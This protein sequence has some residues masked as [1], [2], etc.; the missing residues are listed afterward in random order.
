MQ[1]ISRTDNSSIVANSVPLSPSTW[2][3]WIAVG[4]LSLLRWLP[5]QIRNALT[6]GIA[7]LAVRRDTSTNRAIRINLQAC[8]PKFDDTV[9]LAITER[10]VA[11]HLQALLML[12]R[13]WWASDQTIINKSRIHN[14]H[15]LDDALK[16]QRPVVLLVTHSAG[17][18]AGLLALAPHY[19]LQGIY[20]PIKNRVL[21]YLVYRGRHRFG[22]VPL[23]RG[24]GLRQLIKGLKEGQLMCY[25]SDEDYGAE[26]SVF[27]PFFS[28]QKATLAMLP[29]LVEKTNALVVPMIAHHD[30]DDDGVDVHLFEALKNYPSGDAIADATI[31]ND[32]IATTIRLQPSQFT[33]KLRIFKTCPHGMGPRYSQVRR[34]EISVDDL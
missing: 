34:G 15:F 16:T 8:F 20:N 6:V 18:D 12:P 21:D 13:N 30:S 31:M 7:K 28:H 26:G 32:A 5:R 2:L 33:W 14:Q 25:L 22:A 10:Y 1:K 24:S 9:R 11:L 23:P 27:A 3:S 17:L 19:P 4:L 29:R